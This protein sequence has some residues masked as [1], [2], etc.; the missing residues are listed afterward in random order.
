MRVR[1][2]L[3]AGAALSALDQVESLNLLCLPG[4]AD[5]ETIAAAAAYCDRRHAFLIIDADRNAKTA[6]QLAAFVQNARLPKT[7]SA[8]VYGPWIEIED[9]KSPG[10][11][12]T[13][14]PS[15]SVAGLYARIDSSLGVWRAAAGANASLTGAVGVASELADSEVELLSGLGLNCIR[16]NPKA[17]IVCWGARTLLSGD[18]EYKYVPVRRMS[19]YIEQSIAQG[20]QWVVFE[21]NAPPLWEKLRASVENF[22]ESLFRQGAFQG[23]RPEQGYFARCGRDT[24]TQ[25][26]IDAGTVL[27]EVG[28]AP[29]RPAEFVILRIG[30]WHPPN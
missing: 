24:M 6:E 22:L 25:Q 5:A 14:P 19:L 1:P 7:A 27:V 18:A 13:V 11:F 2:G 17:G 26:D 12:L 20:T 23:Q 29:L 30:I 4:I 15:G 21:P 10:Q 28:F 8:A 9:A 16:Q 3:E